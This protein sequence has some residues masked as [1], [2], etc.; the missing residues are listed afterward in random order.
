MDTLINNRGIIEVESIN[1]VGG[2][3]IKTR[4]H[5][6]MLYVVITGEFKLASAMSDFLEI[7]RAIEKNRSTKVVIDGRQVSGE[8]MTIERFLYGEFVAEAAKRVGVEAAPVFAYVL[9]EPV[10][11]PMRFGETVALN[12]G[13]NLKVFDDYDSAVEWLGT[14]R[15][16]SESHG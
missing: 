1:G 6:N 14:Y 2:M 15:I 4:A 7:L 16:N 5:G 11:D 9:H 12:R 3:T 13:M 8:P 10:L